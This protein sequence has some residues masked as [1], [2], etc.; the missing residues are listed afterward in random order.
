MEWLRELESIFGV[1]IDKEQYQVITDTHQ[2]LQ[3]IAG[4]GSGKTFTI[5]CKVYYLVNVKH[6]KESEILLLSYTN[7]ACNEICD[8]L[9][10]MKLNIEVITFHKFS[11]KILKLNKYIYHIQPDV[12]TISNAFV[13]DLKIRNIKDYDK[14]FLSY[15]VT[16]QWKNRLFI[17]YYFYIVKKL[18]LKNQKSLFQEYV[19]QEIQNQ[20]NKLL[21]RKFEQYK[22]S[23]HFLTFDDMVKVG[24]SILK[25]TKMTFTYKFLIIDEFQDISSIRF[26]FIY[27]YYLKTNCSVVVVGDDY[28]SIYQFADSNVYYFIHFLDYFKEGIQVFLNHTYRNSQEL[29][30]Y[31]KKIIDYNTN[32]IEKKLYSNKSLK[33]PIHYIYYGNNNEFLKS[34]KYLLYHFYKETRKI[35]ILLLSRYQHDFDVLKEK[36]VNRLLK[37]CPTYI[38]IDMLTIHKAKG[39]GYDEVILL[40]LRQGKYGF[41]STEMKVD[42]EEERRLLYVA[43]TRTKNHVYLFVPKK[44]PS[45]F[46]EELKKNHES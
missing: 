7:Y 14:L 34:I 24:L 27:E 38:S 41:P 28:Q 29:L 16:K 12:R 18:H 20:E 31:A 4:A 26:Q 21:C 35:K 39:L 17:Y 45:I 11:L 23:H 9:K 30:E 13:E 6:V 3:V 40:N 5:C 42:M 8:Y 10:K 25:E 44:N 22:Q 2:C 36:N 19:Y 43:L 37:K 15:R 32:Q 33:N 46:I 1:K